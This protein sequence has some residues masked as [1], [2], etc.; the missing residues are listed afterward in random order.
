MASMMI[1]FGLRG[2]SA[3]AMQF[4]RAVLVRDSPSRPSAAHC[5]SMPFIQAVGEA[6]VG[7]TPDM[8]DSAVRERLTA[9]F[10]RSK[11]CAHLD[12]ADPTTRRSSDELLGKL[13]AGQ[14]G[15]FQQW[16]SEEAQIG[17][18]S[19]GNR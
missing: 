18:Q 16:V 2:P 15:P 9:A 7:A 14:L 8:A 19:G 5:L 12:V 11:G 3:H 10:N 17:A 13:Q 6:G 4:V 1:R